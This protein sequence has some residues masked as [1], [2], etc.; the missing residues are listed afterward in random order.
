MLIWE[1]GMVAGSY[2][3]LDALGC[4]Q[5]SNREEDLRLL[6]GYFAVSTSCLVK[7]LGPEGEGE[8][9]GL[10]LI[11]VQV[12][13]LTRMHNPIAF[14]LHWMDQVSANNKASVVLTRLAGR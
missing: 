10:I 9:E 8:R 1:D 7:N 14:V 5:S 13:P 2:N 6:E 12:Y 4:P 11:S 3:I